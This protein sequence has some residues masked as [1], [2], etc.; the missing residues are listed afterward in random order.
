M[1]SLKLGIKAFAA[2][3]ISNKTKRSRFIVFAPILSNIEIVVFEGLGSLKHILCLPAKSQ[4]CRQRQNVGPEIAEH[5]SLDFVRVESFRRSVE[6]R[7]F[8][9][10][11]F[12]ASN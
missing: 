9:P 3:G 8:Y 7:H 11:L 12:L 6:F 5:V 4:A 1:I 10:A 2:S